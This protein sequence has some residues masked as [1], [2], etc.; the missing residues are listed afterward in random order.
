V[1][2]IMQI[3]D[4]VLHVDDF[5]SDIIASYGAWTLAF[6]FLIIF[7]ETGVVVMPFLPG[8]SLIFA[9]A[10]FAARGDINPWLLFILLSIAAI[11]GD[12]VNYW[13]GHRIGARAYSGEVKW[14]K[15]EYMDR[16]HIFFEKHG[17]K[18][19]FLARF[20]PIVRTF[21]PFVA[22]I[23]Q[24]PYGFFIRWNIIGGVVWV[25]IFTLLGYFFGNID[26]VEKNFELVIIAIIGISFVPV[27]IEG[28]KARKEFQKPK[29]GTKA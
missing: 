22:G 4:F 19:I 21:A 17:G 5:L 27:V 1:D 15:K 12:T 10:T 24:M 8:D 16:T 3:V 7:I 13:I 25:A 20:V 6:L 23:S 28:L 14:V 2:F 9:A 26:F 29:V 18:T 11:V